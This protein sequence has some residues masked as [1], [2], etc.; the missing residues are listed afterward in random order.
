VAAACEG[1]V[2]AFSSL[3]EI[4][5]MQEQHERGKKAPITVAIP[6]FGRDEVLIQ[7]VTYLL[8]QP[9]PPAEILVLDQTQVHSPAVA[10]TLKTWENEGRLR[11]LKI[12]RPSIPGSMNVGLV[13]AKNDIVL[14]VDDDII[15]DPG[16]PQAHLEAHERTG[17]AL[18]AGR[19]IQP[20]QEDIDFSADDDLHLA[21]L[22]PHWTDKFIGCNFS[23]RRKKAIALG[24]FDE[25]FVRVAYQ[26]E[27]EFAYRWVSAGE[28]IYFEPAACIHHLKLK[29]GGTRSF[30]DHLTTFKPNHAVGAYYY[31]LRTPGTKNRFLRMLL[32]PLRS[33]RTKHHLRHPW[34]MPF[35]LVSEFL[36]FLWALILFLHGPRYINDHLTDRT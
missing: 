33:V 7:T 10:E 3:K 13:E 16:L 24:G 11:H 20:W 22:T 28:K 2:E 27:A 19:V 8:E 36:G 9:S 31:L 4:V 25:N 30:G 32:R 29:K 5:A 12:A 1:L 14:F 21:S 34:W 26:Y 15:P 18:I 17:A 35:T 6:T 23:V